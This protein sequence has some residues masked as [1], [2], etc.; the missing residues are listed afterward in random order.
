MITPR[1]QLQSSRESSCNPA[2]NPA[3]I[4]PRIQLQTSRESSYNPAANPATNEPRIQLQTSREF[5][6]NPTANPATASE[7]SHA[8][9]GVSCH[10][11]C[12]PAFHRASHRG[13]GKRSGRLALAVMSILANAPKPSHPPFKPSHPPFK[14]SHP[15]SRL[16]YPSLPALC[17]ASKISRCLSAMVLIFPVSSHGPAVELWVSG[18]AVLG[19]TFARRVVSPLPIVLE[20]V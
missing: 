12:H 6:C 17:S 10:P 3:T 15:P 11:A 8:S 4:Q 16:H 5:S 7:S 9:T 2:A 20:V 13:R 1:I 18:F 19:L 14:P